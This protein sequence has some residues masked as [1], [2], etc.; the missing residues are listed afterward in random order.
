MWLISA[1]SLSIVMALCVIGVFIPRKFFDD[2]L[3]Q[4]IGMAGVFM[5]CWPRLMQ[6][7]EHRE[8]TSIAM[9]AEAQ[10]AGHVGLALYAIGTAYKAWKHRP[11]DT[12]SAKPPTSQVHP[13][14]RASD[15][16]P[17]DLSFREAMRIRGQG[18]E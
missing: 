1:A 3:G 2:N 15:P 6:L 9:P 16:L 5:F 11:R 13:F 10:M 17:R 4:C 8:L 12:G 7:I 14:R 18:L